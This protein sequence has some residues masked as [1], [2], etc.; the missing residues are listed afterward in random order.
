MGDHP[1]AK[2]CTFPVSGSIKKLIGDN[3]IEG[4]NIFFQAA[5]GGDGYNV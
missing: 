2:K 1:I 4:L 5:H 3:D